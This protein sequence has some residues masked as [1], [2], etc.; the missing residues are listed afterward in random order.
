MMS[1]LPVPCSQARGQAGFEDGSSEGSRL[2]P[3]DLP[4]PV[5]HPGQGA[6]R[7]EGLQ[8]QDKMIPQEEKSFTGHIGGN[9]KGND[10]PVF[11]L[12]GISQGTSYT[13]GII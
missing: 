13:S 11:G 4:H 8:E 12:Q 5:P 1:L 7:H 2:K 6:P 3:S 9:E 10:S